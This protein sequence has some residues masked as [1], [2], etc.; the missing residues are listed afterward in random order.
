MNNIRRKE[1]KKS[2]A[3]LE[4]VISL[5]EEIAGDL[6]LIQEEEQEA[7]DNMPEGLQESERGE[8]MQECVDSFDEILSVLN[9]EIDLTE[10]IEKLN[11]M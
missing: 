9:D 7:F 10:I 5:I 8:K 3:K 11:E 6:E 2:I 4:T 1:I